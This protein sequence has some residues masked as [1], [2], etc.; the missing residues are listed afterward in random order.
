MKLIQSN[1]F[2]QVY[3]K[4]SKNILT[5]VNDNI[6]AIIDNP[7]I[8]SSK[9]G[10]LYGIRVHKFKCQNHLYLLAYAFN[11]QTNILYLVALGEHE[12]F[13]KKIKRH[14]NTEE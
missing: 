11:S 8:G 5:I 6:K 3:K 12:N 4:L 10:D 13:Y 1:L 7:E 2:K 14:L 9:K